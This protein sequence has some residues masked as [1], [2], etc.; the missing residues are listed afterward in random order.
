MIWTVE[1]DYGVFAAHVQ[2]V[3]VDII[4]C[5]VVLLEVFEEAMYL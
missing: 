4:M 5:T 2:A 3:H 1:K